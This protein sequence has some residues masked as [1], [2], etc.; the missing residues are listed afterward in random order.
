MEKSSRLHPTQEAIVQLQQKPQEE[1]LNE[2]LQIERI[3]VNAQKKKRLVTPRPA[4]PQVI[5][6]MNLLFKK[7]GN[8]AKENKSRKPVKIWTEV[9]SKK[10]V[11]HYKDN[12]DTIKGKMRQGAYRGK[13]GYPTAVKLDKSYVTR[14]EK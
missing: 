10:G 11:R 7:N 4:K 6:D 8:S 5:E 13:K 14:E 3:L 12:V 2:K 1:R 9:E